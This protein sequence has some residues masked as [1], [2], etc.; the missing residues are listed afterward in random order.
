MEGPTI[1][2]RQ[3]L[4]KGAHGATITDKTLHVTLQ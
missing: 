1:F 3:T 2:P 4:T